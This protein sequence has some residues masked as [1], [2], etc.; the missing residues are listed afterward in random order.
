VDNAAN[1]SLSRQAARSRGPI[2]LE[3]VRSSANIQAGART[4]LSTVLHGIWLLVFVA[5]FLTSL[6]VWKVLR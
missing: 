6:S 2:G 1:A 5:V 4:R 3:I